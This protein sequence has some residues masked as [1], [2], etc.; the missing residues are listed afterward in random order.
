MGVPGAVTV[1]VAAIGL[2]GS[3]VEY[4]V[5]VAVLGLLGSMVEYEEAEGVLRVEDA[6]AEGIARE[7][8]CEDFVVDR[9][10]VAICM[11]F[12]EPVVIALTVL[13]D[14]GVLL[15]SSTVM[16]RAEHCP[17]NAQYCQVAQ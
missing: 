7:E 6:L 17:A 12:E 13:F 11:E 4:D 2:L 3:M 8:T 16:L 15:W 10:T 5:S 1:S 9:G 14:V